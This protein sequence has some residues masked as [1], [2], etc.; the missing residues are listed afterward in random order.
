MGNVQQCHLGLGVS[1]QAAA[2]LDKLEEPRPEGGGTRN[3]SPKEEHTSQ[4]WYKKGNAFC[5]GCSRVCWL[6]HSSGPG[7]G[8][9]SQ[10]S[11]RHNSR[12]RFCIWAKKAGAARGSQTLVVLKFREV[13]KGFHD[14]GVYA[15]QQLE[16]GTAQLARFWGG[17]PLRR[18]A[19]HSE[20]DRSSMFTHY[21]G[22]S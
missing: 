11:S 6:R 17:T 15:P 22:N 8:C 7:Q 14:S 9:R 3:A 16:L 5:Q 12:K 18:S 10:Q 19:L 4:Q 21:T 20:V 2:W 13:G 1:L